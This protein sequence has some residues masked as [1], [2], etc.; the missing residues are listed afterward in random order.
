M[1]QKMSLRQQL[2]FKECIQSAFANSALAFAK[3]TY[4]EVK[5][6][7]ITIV[8]DNENNQTAL[9][10]DIIYILVSELKG[11]LRGKCY[12]NFT[13]KDA[14]AL[15]ELALPAAYIEDTV[16]QKA[17]LLE[18]DNILTAAVVSMLSNTLKINTYAYVPELIMGNKSVLD[19]LLNQDYNEQKL[20]L[21]FKTVFSIANHNLETEFIWVLDESFLDIVEFKP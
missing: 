18:L 7:S 1:L 3:F 20:V 5:I 21:Q 8:S 4:K 14:E 13:D 2:F 11:D 16:M 10:S 17:I 12:L 19:N 15:F 6:D 9:L